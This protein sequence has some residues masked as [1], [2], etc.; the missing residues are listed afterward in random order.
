MYVEQYG[1]RKD[2]GKGAEYDKMTPAEIKSVCRIASRL[3]CNWKE[4]LPFV[5][6]L[7]NFRDDDLTRMQEWARTRTVSA[8]APEEVN[9]S[10][11]VASKIA[12]ISRKAGK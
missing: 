5:P 7:H 11:Q 9:P 1:L 3:K 2:F 10:A 6:C 12:G 4:A 8:E